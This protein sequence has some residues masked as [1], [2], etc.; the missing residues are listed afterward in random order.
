M[1]ELDI[2]EVVNATHVEEEKLTN[3]VMVRGD[4]KEL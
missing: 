3:S 1:K 2:L 4:L